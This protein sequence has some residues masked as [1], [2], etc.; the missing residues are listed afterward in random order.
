MILNSEIIYV[1]SILMNKSAMMCVSNESCSIWSQ[2]ILT[3]INKE[4][5]F[6]AYFNFRPINLI[7]LYG[8]KFRKNE[9]IRIFQLKKT[10]LN[11]LWKRISFDFVKFRFQS[12]CWINRFFCFSIWEFTK[13]WIIIIKIDLINWFANRND[14]SR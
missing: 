14:R 3:G 13:K 5:Y 12:L 9:Q 4:N 1:K 10:N 6:R 8:W 11:A 7:V 2:K